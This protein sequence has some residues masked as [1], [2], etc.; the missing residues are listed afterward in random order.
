MLGKEIY[1]STDFTKFIVDVVK[2]SDAEIS[3]IW[4]CPYQRAELTPGTWYTGEESYRKSIRRIKKVT[5]YDNWNMEVSYPDG[6]NSYR[7]KREDRYTL[8]YI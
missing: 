6:D 7:F 1:Y 4:E 2:S 5:E 3:Y 8:N